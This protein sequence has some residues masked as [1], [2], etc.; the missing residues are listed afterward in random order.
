[1]TRAGFVLGTPYY[2]APEQVLG[3]NVTDQ[4]DVYAFGMLLFELLTGVKPISGDTVE[5][6]FYSI[7]NEPLNL[8]PLRQADV[9]PAVVDLVAR[10][11][12]KDP[13]A[14]AAGLR[15]GVRGNWRA[16]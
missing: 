10:C 7:L 13:A 5:R 4:V 12:A 11:T 9:P 1:M 16:S 6:I 15:A 14:A 2:M 3:K 8:E